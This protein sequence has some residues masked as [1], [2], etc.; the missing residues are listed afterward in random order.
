MKNL[1][2]AICILIIT[3]Y[4]IKKKTA[5]KQKDAACAAADQLLFY[6]WVI[7]QAKMR[8][9]P[10]SYANATLPENCKP[11]TETIQI[12]NIFL[13][14]YTASRLPVNA[15]TCMLDVLTE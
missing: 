1:T 3:A 2:T 5:K 14:S 10:S 13:A 12:L 11:F 7:S 4:V 9:Y 6:C 8:N 15:C